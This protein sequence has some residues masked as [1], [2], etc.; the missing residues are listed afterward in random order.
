MNSGPLD[1]LRQVWYGQ[2]T[3]RTFH[4]TRVLCTGAQRPAMHALG[5]CHH[6]QLGVADG[7]G[8]GN[9]DH[10]IQR[11][12]T[13]MAKATRKKAAKTGKKAK[14]SSAAAKAT[15]TKKKGGGAKAKA[16]GAKV[17]KATAYTCSTCGRVASEKGHLCTPVMA[18]KS[19]TCDHCGLTSTNARHL[20][21]PKV[22]AIKFACD[23]CGRVAP[24]KNQLCHP[25]AI[26]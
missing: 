17:K 8:V 19:Y 6:K 25:K 11:E 4:A 26:K 9:H 3:L 12:A 1:G 24:Q 2:I 5:V 21:K 18:T 14:S 23:T 20:C 15:R 7:V 22:A 16:A 10:S 13:I